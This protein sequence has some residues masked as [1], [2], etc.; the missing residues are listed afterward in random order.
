[1]RNKGF[2]WF[3]TI[4]LALVCIYQ[5]SFTF[6]S[7]GVEADADIE[8]NDKYDSIVDFHKANAD[9]GDVVTL[10]D[11]SKFSLASSRGEDSAKSYYSN[12]YLKEMSKEDV[13]P[14]LDKTYDEVK[15]QSINLGLDLKGGMSVTLELSVPHLVKNIVTDNRDPKFKD[16]F[17]KTKVMYDNGEGDF[18][19]LFVS[20]YEA[21][22]VD[23][24][25]ADLFYEANAE[26]ERDMTNEQ[27]AIFLKKTATDALG[28]VE[29]V[30]N[31]R[32]NQFG[33]SQPNITKDP[34]SNRVMVEL[35]G[36]KD[37][38]TVRRRLQS[39]ANLMFFETYHAGIVLGAIGDQELDNDFKNFKG[40]EI[41]KEIEKDTLLLDNDST[42]L[43]S[44]N[45]LAKF[46]QF[47]FQQ[48]DPENGQQYMAFGKNVIGLAKAVDTATIGAFFRSPSMMA[49]LKKVS[50]PENMLVPMWGTA[51]GENGY[52]SFYSIKVP[53][54]GKAKVGGKDIGKAQQGYDEFNKANISFN[55]V[56]NG[57]DKWGQLTKENVGN[58]IA[59]VM[60]NL[61]YSAPNV[62]VANT[63]GSAQI[64]GNFTIEEA[65]GLSD[66]LNGGSLPAPC[67]IVEESS[68]G[69]TLADENIDSGLMSFGI[70]LLVVLAYMI[71]Y[72]GKA[73]VVAD[74]ALVANM[75]FIVGALAS[76]KA[77][78]TLAGIAGIVLTIGMSVDA[79]VLIFERIREELKNG[80]G[81]KMAVGDGYKKALAAI[82]DAN[83]TTLLTAVV[84]KVFG[85]GPIE[86]FAT[87]LIIGIFT[88]VFAAVVVTRLIFEIAIKKNADIKFS[89]SITKN[90]FQ[91]MNYGFVKN[92]KKFYIFS[93]ILI[94][95]G[96]GSLAFRG[97]DLGVEFTGGHTYL[98]EF[99][100][101]F[102]KVT[103]EEAMTK[104]ME[105]NGENGS[106]SVKQ[107]GDSH[108]AEI[109]TKFLNGKEGADSL[110]SMKVESGLKTLEADYGQ[111]EI[112]TT[113]AILPVISSELKTSS[114]LA[115]LVSLIIIFLYILI[116]FGKWQYGLGALLAMAHDV[117]LVLAIFS[118]GYGW[119]P[120]S[121]EMDQA[122]IAAL[123]TVVGYSINDT[124]V[125][126]DRIREYIGLNKMKDRKEVI[127][128]AL[129]STLSRTINTSLSTFVVLLMIFLLGGPAIKGFVFALMVGV[130]VGTYS[131]LCIA[132]PTVVDLTK[133]MKIK[134][135]ETE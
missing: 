49:R 43:L 55:M 18:I 50:D 117:L 61:V 14:F 113:R 135:G 96:I 129:N 60:D 56:G 99:E 131:S 5:I 116:R 98:V 84:L 20:T 112:V 45:G 13:H 64:T 82:L 30:I 24:K 88:S 69:P 42:G 67:K 53:T 62:T 97:L 38:A 111:G 103:V 16:V 92:R 105:H 39:T 6:I 110:L 17:N 90:W 3:L 104:V 54:D 118:I 72:Y 4:V 121:M 115:I 12:A 32:V 22:Y 52:I 28:G 119:M 80:K 58:T 63:S 35:P 81:L 33:V 126:F 37:R 47:N 57:P 70:A 41:E 11:N 87:T 124:V 123:L 71:F 7:N 40:I 27:V 34:V 9:A 8:A 25:V 107:K 109:M 85:T 21:D 95:G 15:S 29:K 2:F 114:F 93:S 94:V 106:V 100:E 51:E 48:K 65:R 108:T 77:V 66:L 128:N 75:L 122:F 19:D 91:N 74:M 133:S 134:E 89:T 83:I 1:M 76:F 44:E 120:F 73:G 102:D 101:S 23:G 86:S 26:V 79:N 59:I 127:N 31:K 132:T 10:P 46:F 78:L 125:V 36:V 130:I 68:V